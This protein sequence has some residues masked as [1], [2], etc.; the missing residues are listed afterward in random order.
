M[1]YCGDNQY[2]ECQQLN[3]LLETKQIDVLLLQEWSANK[4]QIVTDQDDIK[5]PKSFSQTTLFTITPPSVQSYI[6]RPLC[7]SSKPAGRLLKSIYT[8]TI[9]TFV[10]ILLHSQTTDTHCY[11]VYRPKKADAINSLNMVRSDRS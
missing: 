10:G 5:F 3:Q 8:D 7:D 2:L 9:F 6:T 4:R 11:S 1:G